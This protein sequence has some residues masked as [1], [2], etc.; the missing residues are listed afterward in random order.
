MVSEPR[1]LQ[2][3]YLAPGR[4]PSS[5]LG[6]AIMI[7][8][9]AARAPSTRGLYAGRWNRFCGWCRSRGEDPVS[10]G[11][12]VVLAFLQSL[13]ESGLSVSTLRGYVAAISGRHELVAGLTMGTQALVGCFLRGAWRLCP[14]SGRL[15]PAWDLRVVLDA[16]TEPPFEPLSSLGWELLSLKMVFLLA[17]ASAKRVSE[18]RALSVHPAC[19]RLGGEGS[20][21]SLLPNPA[22]LPK[23]LSRF[24]V[25]RPLV[26]DPF[27][28]LPHES[29]EVARLHLV[30]LVWALRSYIACTSSSRQTDQLFVCFGEPVRDQAVSKQRLARWVVRAIELA[31][32]S[33]ALAPPT[34]VVAHS[35]RGMPASWA[36]FRGASLEEVCAATGWASSLTF[37]RFYRLNVASSVAASVLQA[38]G[39]I[40]GFSFTIVLV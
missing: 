6:A 9:Q 32:S 16:I 39:P 35:T 24:F 34:G 11:A 37:A 4:G 8:L 28:P 31:Y 10:C 2:A 27:H 13:L 1:V 15:I 5:D 20:A 17:I 25:A 36:L 14:P 19:M 18:L 23:V 26:L 33:A 21:I 30:C 22:F 7:T 40:D 3:A 38:A 29:P 12:S